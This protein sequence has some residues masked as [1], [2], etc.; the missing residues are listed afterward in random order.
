MPHT[1]YMKDI[2][3][4]GPTLRRSSSSDEPMWTPHARLII[5]GESRRHYGYGHLPRKDL[6]GRFVSTV[7]WP[8]R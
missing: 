8:G 3:F 1:M 6:F 5:W 7:D 2:P 4:T